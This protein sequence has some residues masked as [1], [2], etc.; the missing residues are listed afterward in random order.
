MPTVPVK[1]KR[2]RPSGLN[3]LPRYMTT[4]AA[5]MDLLADLVDDLVIAP[6][7][8][9]LVPT[10]IAIALPDGYEAQIRPR[11]GLALKHGISLVN[12]PGTIDPDYRGEIG[13]IVINHGSEPF[14]VKNGERIAQMVVAPFVRAEWEEA[15][16][17]DDTHRG[18]G[19]FGHTGR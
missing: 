10:G 18:D 8:R 14:V 16:E 13:V 5:G 19:G 15:D 12:T 9:V 4:H 1:I 17:L 2:I 7:E 3:P 11:S 6:G